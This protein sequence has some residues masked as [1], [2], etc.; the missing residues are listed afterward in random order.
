MRP[1]EGG[2]DIGAALFGTTARIESTCHATGVPVRLSVRASGMSVVEP[3]PAVVS[4]VNPEDMSSV[5]PAFCNQVHFFAFAEAAQPRLDA[6]PGGSG[7]PVAEAHRI[8]HGHGRVP[9]R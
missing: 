8:G 2:G 3:I 9:A 7:V 4:L 6:H 5:R 1:R